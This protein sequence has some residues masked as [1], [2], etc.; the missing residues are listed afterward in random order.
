MTPHEEQV[1]YMTGLIDDL[2]KHF[3]HERGLAFADTVNVLLAV[4][5]VTAFVDGCDRATYLKLASDVWDRCAVLR[6]RMAQ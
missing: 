4:A 6:G 3:A 2:V 1:E 5:T